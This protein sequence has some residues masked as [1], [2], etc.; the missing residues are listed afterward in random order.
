MSF[1]AMKGSWRRLVENCLIYFFFA[2]VIPV[3][4]FTDKEGGAQREE[5]DLPITKGG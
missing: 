3:F 5:V 2:P 4:R 1:W